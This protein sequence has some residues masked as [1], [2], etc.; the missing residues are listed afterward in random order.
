MSSTHSDVP[1]RLYSLM[2]AKVGSHPWWPAMLTYDPETAK[3][4]KETGYG[5]CYLSS[6]FVSLSIGS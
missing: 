2:W 4:V 5:C 6:S 1:K 3:V